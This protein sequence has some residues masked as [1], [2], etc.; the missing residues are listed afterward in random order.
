MNSPAACSQ[1]RLRLLPIKSGDSRLSREWSPRQLQR[2]CGFP[3]PAAI[4]SPDDGICHCKAGQL[5]GTRFFAWL[6]AP[7][8]R[9]DTFEGL[10]YVLGRAVDHSGQ[11]LELSD[12]SVRVAGVTLSPKNLGVWSTKLLFLRI[13]QL[14]EELLAWPQAREDDFDLIFRLTGKA[15]QVVCQ[16]QDLDWFTHVEN[17]NLSPLAQG[18]SL[19]DQLRRLGD[20]HEV[21][22]H[23]GVRDGH[24]LPAADLLLEERDNA[25]IGSQ[26]VAEA[27]RDHAAGATLSLGLHIHLSQTLA[28][29]H[30]AR[31]T[32]GLVGG[33]PDKRP[34][35]GTDRLIDLGPRTGDGTLH[36]LARIG[37]H[38]RHM[39]VGGCVENHVGPEFSES[40]AKARRIPERSDH[41]NHLGVRGQCV[42]FSLEVEQAILAMVEQNEPSGL[43]S[44]YLAT[45]LRANASC[46]PRDQNRPASKEATDRLSVE[47]DWIA[48]EKIL[49]IHIPRTKCNGT[50]HQFTN[51]WDNL[52]LD[53]YFFAASDKT[54][55]LSWRDGRSRNQKSL[56]PVP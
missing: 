24:R 16:V 45:E 18:T 22:G 32:H 5:G 40:G 2:S 47:M 4:G 41:G 38:Q 10:D 52:H 44:Q 33:D 14:L 29:A 25:A 34:K 56:D 36:G 51:S 31:R 50:A 17:K 30:D 15:D 27:D 35:S 6:A 1:A 21:A 26:D 42:E 20:G 8:P 37:F 23:F 46:C 54:P 28:C 43:E 19:E 11:A 48:A 39:L 9:H 13:R 55:N 53:A 49:N 3:I 7:V 12:E